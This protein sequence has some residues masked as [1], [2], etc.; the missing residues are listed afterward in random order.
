MERLRRRRGVDSRAKGVDRSRRA[1]FE[2]DPDVAISRH[3]LLPDPLIGGAGFQP[4][5]PTFV[6]QKPSHTYASNWR[7][8]LNPVRRYSLI[9]SWFEFV[10]VRLT[11]RHPSS[12]SASSA[13]RSNSYP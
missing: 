5:K 1:D 4:P 11:L 9:A 12:R 6:I 7:C 13:W 10:T 3:A 2:R 8:V